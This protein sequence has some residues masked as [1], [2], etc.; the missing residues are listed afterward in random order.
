MKQLLL[1]VA[2]VAALLSAC[3]PDNGTTTTTTSTSSASCCLGPRPNSRY[4]SCPSSD[5]ATKC[6]NDGSP[7]TCSADSSKDSTCN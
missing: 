7:G 6:F 1:T 3:G 5:A 4:Y 2:A